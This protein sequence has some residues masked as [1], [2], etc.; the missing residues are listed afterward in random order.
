MKTLE[1]LAREAA[2]ERARFDL[3]RCAAG[4]REKA[5]EMFESES[6]A[7][8]DGEA[9]AEEMAVFVGQL[10][11]VW[12]RMERA[13]G[14][15]GEVVTLRLPVATL[16]CVCEMVEECLW[17]WGLLVEAELLAD[18]WGE[19]RAGLI[20]YRRWAAREAAWLLTAAGSG[21]EQVSRQ[22]AGE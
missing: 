3:G 1:D 13:S 19:E 6:E 21:V 10:V 17:E 9:G 18:D 14:N 2:E 22:V 8:A 20:R 16:V 11:G 7:A 15:G 5:E 4:R 12:S